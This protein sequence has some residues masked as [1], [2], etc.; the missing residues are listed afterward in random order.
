MLGERG[1]DGNGREHSALSTDVFEDLV[2]GP[3][4]AYCTFGF[5]DINSDSHYNSADYDALRYML[6]NTVCLADDDA[7]RGVDMLINRICS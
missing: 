4:G 2:M 6:E 3:R 1:P 5:D 7:R